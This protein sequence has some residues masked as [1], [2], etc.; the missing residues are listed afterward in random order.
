MFFHSKAKVITNQPQQTKTLQVNQSENDETEIKLSI[1]LTSHLFTM[2]WQIKC[3]KANLDGMTSLMTL[4]CNVCSM[5][6]IQFLSIN[7]VLIVA[8]RF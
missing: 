8:V 2:S 1:K 7:T 6:H 4:I 5:H 3:L